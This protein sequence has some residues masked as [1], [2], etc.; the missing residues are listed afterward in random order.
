M[1]PW[2]IV[3]ATL[4]IFGTGVVTGGLLVSYS[5]RA[6][7]SSTPQPIAANNPRPVVGTT[8]SAPRENRIPPPMPAPLRKDFLDRLERELSLTTVQRERIEKIIADGQEQ[9]RQLWQTVEPQMRGELVTTRERIRNE[10]TSD[11]IPRFEDIM[12]RP[13]RRP[14]EVSTNRP[15]M[16]R[17]GVPARGGVN[18]DPTPP[19]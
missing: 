15:P 3:V 10:L 17:G 19:H 8:N 5:D 6:L 14:D 4:I 9:T 11:Q 16:R 13:L 12:R 7:H 18:S 1:N 2:K